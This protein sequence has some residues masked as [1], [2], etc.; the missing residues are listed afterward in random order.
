[1]EEPSIVV[2]NKKSTK[3]LRLILRTLI[4]FIGVIL[5]AIGATFLKQGL[6]GLDPFTATN[7]GLSKMFG[8]GLGPTQLGFNLILFILVVLFDRHEIGIG[9]FLNMILIGFGIQYFSKI[10]TLMLG[11]HMHYSLIIIDAI[12]GIAIFTLGTSLY[13]EADLGVAPYDAIAPIIVKKTHLK[14]QYVRAC[15]DIAFMVAGWFVHGDVGFMTIIVAFFAGPLI[16]FWNVHVSRNIVNHTDSFS[17]NKKRAKRV[18]VGTVNAWKVGLYLIRK[19]YQNTYHIQRNMSTYTDKE[20][21]DL[22]DHTEQRLRFN[23]MSR[24]VLSQRLYKLNHEIRFRHLHTV[25]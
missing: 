19:G 3:L 16:N 11:T 2:P 12:V 7:I 6:V 23:K 21:I 5:I 15:Q 4:S 9:T 25:K 18:G 24:K 22:K 17:V 14:Y 1:M 13:M 8:M 20:L 10:Y